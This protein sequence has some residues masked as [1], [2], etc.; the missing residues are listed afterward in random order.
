MDSI[1]LLLI[2]DN[3]LLRNGMASLLNNQSD[4]E[5][6]GASGVRGHN[7]QKILLF[8]PDV[9]LLD[10]GLRNHNGIIVMKMLKGT[11]PEARIIVM[12][13]LPV[14]ADIMPFVEMGA[15]GFIVKDATVDT[16]IETIRAVAGGSKVLP[17]LMIETLFTEIAS[18]TDNT[19]ISSNRKDLQ[20]TARELEVIKLVSNGLSD[21]NIGFRLNISIHTVKSHLQ[22]VMNKLSL[23]TRFELA[24]L[25]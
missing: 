11:F 19:G 3:R 16:F 14:I 2:E 17:D 22:N 1:K 9:I 20:I 21:E 5:I 24:K 23:Y 18:E 10:M 6:L 13:L 8:K 25:K 7:I 15:A 4:I 12:D